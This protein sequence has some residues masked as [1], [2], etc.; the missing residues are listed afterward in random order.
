MRAAE[1]TNEIPTTLTCSFVYLPLLCLPCSS[2]DHIYSGM[3]L[4]QLLKARLEGRWVGIT[5][6]QVPCLPE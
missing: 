1:N 5:V 6:P 4:S 2:R 3:G